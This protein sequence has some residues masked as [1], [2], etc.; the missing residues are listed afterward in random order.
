MQPYIM[1]NLINKSFLPMTTK[2]KSAYSL[3][4]LLFSVN[5]RKLRTLE[6]RQ[7]WRLLFCYRS[8]TKRNIYSHSALSHLNHSAVN[9]FTLFFF[10]F[11]NTQ[12]TSYYFLCCPSFFFLLQMNFKKK[13]SFT[14]SISI[15]FLPSL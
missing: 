12:L 7:R 14:E 2:S 11:S 9:L 15:S 10:F 13:I 8:T 4:L 3:L 6:N 1:M 5:R